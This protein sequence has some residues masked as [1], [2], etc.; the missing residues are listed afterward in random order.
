MHRIKSALVIA[1][2]RDL[3]FIDECIKIY[4]VDARR[5]CLKNVR[6]SSI[7]LKLITILKIRLIDHP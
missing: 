3:L 2:T 6:N 4:D 5:I 1:S 7:C